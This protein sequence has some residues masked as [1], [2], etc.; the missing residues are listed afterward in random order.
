MYQYLAH[1]DDQVTQTDEI[2]RGFDARQAFGA[3]RVAIPL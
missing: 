3:V 2:V 1:L